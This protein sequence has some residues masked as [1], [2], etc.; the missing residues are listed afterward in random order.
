MAPYNFL[1]SSLVSVSDGN[2]LKNGNPACA[3]HT[4]IGYGISTLLSD[5]FVLTG[6]FNLLNQFFNSEIY[7]QIDW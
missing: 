3:A 4:F 1:P 5:L 2:R 7:T 6:I